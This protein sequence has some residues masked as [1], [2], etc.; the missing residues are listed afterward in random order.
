MIQD[1]RPAFGEARDQG[2]RPTCLAFAV[3]DVHAVELKPF[4]PLSV[5]YL[6]YHAVLRM[7]GRDPGQ[8]ITAKAA[9]GAL[10][11]EGQPVEGQWPY[12]HSLPMDL[13]MWI[14]PG[15]CQPFRRD[16]LVDGKS[17]D[18]V[19]TS[20]DAARAVVLALVISESFYTPNADGIVEQKNPDPDTGLH[21]VVAV[22]HGNSA[23]DNYILV[24]NSWGPEWGVQGHGF[25]ERRY[26]ERRL[27]LTA[28]IITGI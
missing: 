22:G 16:L 21:A 15:N 1:L 4:R 7:P 12:Q 6:F 3:S 18:Q 19:C 17:V 13:S 26:L 23:N 9:A 14:P 25:L 10:V 5:E 8:A 27:V 24:R 20:L 28:E 11:T 2:S